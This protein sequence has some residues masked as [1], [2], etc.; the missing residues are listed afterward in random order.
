MTNVLRITTD[1]I[2]PGESD[3]ESS[4]LHN[5]AAWLLAE[6]ASLG[7]PRDAIVLLRAIFGSANDDNFD[8]VQARFKVGELQAAA[9]D[10]PKLPLVVCVGEHESAIG[11]VEVADDPK[12]GYVQL[13]FYA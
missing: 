3:T 4:G 7:T 5:T 2:E 12:A 11:D 6:L 8:E 1:G 9:A 10:Y 13:F